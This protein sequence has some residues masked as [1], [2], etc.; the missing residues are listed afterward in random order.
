[1]ADVYYTLELGWT[2]QFTATII[3]VTVIL[4]IVVGRSLVA[5]L[6]AVLAGYTVYTTI[7]LLGL[8]PLSWI[9]FTSLPSLLD[10]F[11]LLF[12]GAYAILAISN[13]RDTSWRLGV[14]VIGFYSLVL[15]ILA[16]AHARPLLLLV[17]A[18]LITS[19]VLHA[20]RKFSL[21]ISLTALVMLVIFYWNELQLLLV[22][23]AIGLA[24]TASTDHKAGKRNATLLFLSIALLT[25]YIALALRSYVL[26]SSLFWAVALM[27]AWSLVEIIRR[28][29]TSSADFDEPAIII[30]VAALFGVV[31]PN[32]PSNIIESMVAISPFTLAALMVLPQR[33]ISSRGASSKTIVAA[34]MLVLVI[35]VPIAAIASSQPQTVLTKYCTK[36][37]NG[38]AASTVEEMI[39]NVRTWAFKYKNLDEAVE[40][41]YGYKSFK[42]YMAYMVKLTGLPSDYTELLVNYFEDMFS[43]AKKVLEAPKTVTISVDSLTQ[44]LALPALILTIVASCCVAFL[45]RR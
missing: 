40:K 19:H 22:S 1:M 29:S 24:I 42:D 2:L 44:K 38:I 21:S 35:Y 43:N 15:A 30:V 9:V 18:L 8:R 20:Y 27:L 32:T 13:T 12:A 6:S 10:R 7:L 37:H 25:L 45:Y 17:F 34:L 4:G 16:F 3:L 31:M 39:T 26:R 23:A 41:L 5:V 33:R 14:L 28:T 11:A 36:C